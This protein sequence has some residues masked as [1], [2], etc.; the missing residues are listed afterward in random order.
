MV[1]RGIKEKIA[2]WES[3][4]DREK[5]ERR[6]EERVG[7]DPTSPKSFT[8]LW[9]KTRAPSWTETTGAQEK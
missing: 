7:E 6:G 1:N 5:E 3:E 2:R 9:W 4:R 8:E